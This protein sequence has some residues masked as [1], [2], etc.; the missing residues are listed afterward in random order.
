MSGKSIQVGT[1]GPSVRNTWCH[2]PSSAVQAVGSSS[3]QG[4]IHV[5]TMWNSEAMSHIMSQHGW[6]SSILSSPVDWAGP[7]TWHFLVRFEK[8]SLL[9]A[10]IGLV[11]KTNLSSIRAEFCTR[12]VSLARLFCHYH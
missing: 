12:K 6:E 7:R 1:I 5:F 11:R 10:L 4:P 9:Y 2:H 8:P 3:C